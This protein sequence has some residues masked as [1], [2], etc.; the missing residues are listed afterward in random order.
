MVSPGYLYILSFA[1][2]RTASFASL[3]LVP[4]YASFAYLSRLFMRVVDLDGSNYN[5]DWQY[6]T[7]I[8]KRF[9]SIL[10]HGDR[11]MVG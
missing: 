10:A 3:E 2:F 1:S 4:I 9:D 5:H 8:P 6:T 11:V 7:T